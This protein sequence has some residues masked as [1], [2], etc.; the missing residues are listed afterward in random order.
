MRLKKVISILLTYVFLVSLFSAGILTERV[1]AAE[2]NTY[3]VYNSQSHQFPI[4][5]I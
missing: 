2:G 4:N 5:L 3:K 1:Y